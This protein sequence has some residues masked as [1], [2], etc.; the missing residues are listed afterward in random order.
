LYPQSTYIPGSELYWSLEM[1]DPR[2]VK[3][4]YI[5]ESSK[6]LFGLQKIKD[7]ENFLNKNLSD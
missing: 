7:F 5:S 3:S 4:K 6:K 1:T 2:L